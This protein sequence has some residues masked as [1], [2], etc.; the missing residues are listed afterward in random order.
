[1][2]N[3]IRGSMKASEIMTFHE[4]D[5]NENPWVDDEPRKE[6]I[7]V[8]AYSSDWSTAFEIQREKIANELGELALTIEHIGST[9]VPA[10]PAKPVIDIDLIVTDPESEDA[11]VPSLKALG[12]ELTVRERSWYRHR[13]L[14]LDHPRVNLH[15]FGHDCPEHLRH[16]LFRDWLLACPDDRQHYADAKLSAK[17]GVDNAHDYNQKKQA[18]VR[19]IYQKIFA[20]RGWLPT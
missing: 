3:A 7:T 4:G 6:D 5:P 18:V 2:E 9:A 15:V 10:L 17:R 14:R 19:E 12:Y 16:L 8:V 1:M 11:Y 20:S 13:M